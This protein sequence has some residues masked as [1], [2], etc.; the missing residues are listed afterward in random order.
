MIR[1]RMQFWGENADDDSLVREVLAGQKTATACPA[2]SYHLPEGDFDSGGWATGDVVEVYDLHGRLR[3]L[4]EITDVYTT[5]WDSFPDR[6]WQEE[7]C[8]DAEHFRE[9]HRYCWPDEDITDDF[10]MTATHFRLLEQYSD[11]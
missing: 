4:I 11:Q 2:A 6:L 8:R 1:K 7:Y 3:C 5:R 9:A 10:L